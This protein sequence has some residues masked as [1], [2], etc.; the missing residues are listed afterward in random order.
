MKVTITET[1]LSLFQK[2]I[3]IQ[4]DHDLENL[5]YRLHERWYEIMSCVNSRT[6]VLR[7]RQVVNEL[8]RR[9]LPVPV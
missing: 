7:Y 2:N 6:T 4:D 9:G 8:Q 3:R 1:R 5:A